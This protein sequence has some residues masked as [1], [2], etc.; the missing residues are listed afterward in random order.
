MLRGRRLFPVLILT[1]AGT[2]NGYQKLH[3]EMELVSGVL[4]LSNFKMYW[5]D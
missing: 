4:C 1:T 3:F 5:A 2:C